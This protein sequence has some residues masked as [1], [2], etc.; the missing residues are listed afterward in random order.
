MNSL[1]RLFAI[2]LALTF[3]AG[4]G[5][6]AWVG[7]LTAGSA[8]K[9]DSSRERRLQDWQDALP[10]L[11]VTQMRRIRTILA[12][13][14]RAVALIRER[15]DRTQWAE[16][17]QLESQNREKLHKVL[18]KSQR[19]KLAERNQGRRDKPAQGK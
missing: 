10:D 19:Q 11:S 14:D 18:T 5:T 17:L 3:V 1:Y 13:H 8:D 4:L 2:V 16:I 7:T 6:G 9:E 12:E 15:L